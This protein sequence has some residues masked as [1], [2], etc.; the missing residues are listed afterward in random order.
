MTTS[1][2]YP[3]S[4]TGWLAR[5]LPRLVLSPS[6]VCVLV[7]VY[8]FIAWTAYLSFSKSRILPNYQLVGL[9]QYQALFESERWWG[10]AH[11]LLIYGVLFVVICMALGLLL[12]ILLDQKIRFEGGI[13]TIYMYPMA[14]SF[15]VTGTAWKWLLNPGLGIEALVRSWGWE[16]FSFDWIVDPDYAIYTVVLAAVWQSSGFVMALFLAGL[17][18]IDESIVKAAQID[19]AS[20]PTIYTRILIPSLGPVFLSAV[21]MLTHI[22]IKSFDLVMALTG[23]GPGFSTDLPAVYMY[24]ISFGRGQLGQGAASA[25]MMLMT[26]LIIIVPFLYVDA[27]GQ[28]RA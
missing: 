26:V 8:G 4:G 19:G 16:T 27:K 14:L 25:M 23:G 21:M 3:K 17:R 24:Q 7:F 20:L 6:F 15:V 10:S 9:K 1:S 5:T 13:R 11:N 12:A 22:A 28:R 18:G 2:Q